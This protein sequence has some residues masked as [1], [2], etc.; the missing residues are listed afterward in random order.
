M[1]AVSSATAWAPS[2][3][4]PTR[5]TT[6]SR[7]EAGRPKSE[8]SQPIQAPACRVRRP[9][10]MSDLRISSKKNGFPRGPTEQEQR[11]ELAHDLGVHAERQVDELA[12]LAR[13]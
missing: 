4:A 5:D 9:L 13:G 7:I 11:G 6:A 12:S 2:E 3:V 1:T 8:A 10:A